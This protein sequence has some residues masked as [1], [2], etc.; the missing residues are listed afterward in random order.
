MPQLGAH[1][2][3][4]LED[5]IRHTAS[6]RR[7]LPSGHA[8]VV[9]CPAKVSHASGLRVPPAVRETTWG[10]TGDQP[11]RAVLGVSLGL[12]SSW[13]GLLEDLLGALGLSCGPL[14]PF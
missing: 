2:P 6:H 12:Y 5:R 14:R 7:P 11:S 8:C 13:L 9:K 4:R 3:G 1:V 10:N